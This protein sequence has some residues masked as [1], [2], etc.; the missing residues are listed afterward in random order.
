[1]NSLRF[2]LLIL[3]ATGVSLL[4]RADDAKKCEVGEQ[5]SVLQIQG[6]RCRPLEY[7]PEVS[8]PGVCDANQVCRT[9]GEPCIFYTNALSRIFGVAK[10]TGTVQIKSDSPNN[11]PQLYCTDKVAPMS[12]HKRPERHPISHPLG[13]K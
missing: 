5:C 7:C 10:K 6:R 11:Q 2:S 12:S 13:V 3:A 8:K 4:I 9:L 1:M